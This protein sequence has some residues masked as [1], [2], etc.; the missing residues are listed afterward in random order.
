MSR[1]R[2]ILAA[3]ALGAVLAGPATAFDP[4]QEAM[5]AAADGQ[6]SFAAGD[7]TAAIRNFLRAQ[8]LDPENEEI[9]MG[10]A[11]TLYKAT[12]FASARR[13][14]ESVGRQREGKFNQQAT[15][16]AGNSAFGEGDLQTALDLYTRALLESDGAASEDLLHNLELT[17]RLLEEQQ[18]QQEQQ[19]GE[20]EDS[21][22]QQDPSEQE[23]EQ[24]QDEQQ[25]QDQ[26]QQEQEQEQQEGQP[27]EE[28][29]QQQ[30]QEG[31]QEEEGEE[32]QQEEFAQEDQMTPEEAMRLLQALDA[33]EEELRKSIQRRLR[34]EGKETEHD[35]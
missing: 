17:Q 9:R 19:Q 1:A 29:E 28:Q 5:R 10:L 8:K 26:Q 32:Q 4:L 20:G 16:N 14:F 25:Q 34:G 11:E 18:E 7:T 6:R 31:D 13:Q 15:Y 12:D 35:W 30:P 2:L 27:E 33:D 23:Q 22:E 3:I 24:Q 21:E